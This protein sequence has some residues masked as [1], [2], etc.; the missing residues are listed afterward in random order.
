MYVLKM[1]QRHQIFVNLTKYT[2][3]LWYVFKTSLE[4]YVCVKNF[5]ETILVIIVNNF[6]KKTKAKVISIIDREINGDKMCV[7]VRNLKKENS[8]FAFFF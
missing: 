2:R 3:R 8:R 6:V 1:S 5:S 7:C 4:L